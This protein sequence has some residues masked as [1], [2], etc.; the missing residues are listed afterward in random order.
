ML[1]RKRSPGGLMDQESIIDV[2]RKAAVEN[3]LSCEKARE[4]AE[5]L[6]VPVGEIGRICN[7]LKIKITTCQLGCF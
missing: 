1:K 2:V 7:V 6:K 5:A 4:L 3:R